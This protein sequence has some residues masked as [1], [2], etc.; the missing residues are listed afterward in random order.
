MK[1]IIF[2]ALILG[3]A[4]IFG[5]EKKIETSSREEIC[6]DLVQTAAQNSKKEQESADSIIKAGLVKNYGDTIKNLRK[7]VVDLKNEKKN[8]ENMAYNPADHPKDDWYENQLPRKE[9]N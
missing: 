1:K 6:K 2:L 3:F 9:S 4:S 8:W 7:K 5:C